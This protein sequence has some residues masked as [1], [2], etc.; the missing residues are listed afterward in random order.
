MGIV[1]VA[2]M[3]ARTLRSFE[4][5]VDETSG[6]ATQIGQARAVGHEAAVFDIFAAPV[7]ARQ[8]MMQGALDKRAAV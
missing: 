6:A 5:L 3:A 2:W 8:L 7:D 1:A 4:D